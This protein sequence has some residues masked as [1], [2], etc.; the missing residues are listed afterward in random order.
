MGFQVGDIVRCVTY[1]YRSCPRNT[2]REVVEVIDTEFELIRLENSQS[3]T[4]YSNYTSA[5]FELVHRPNKRRPETMAERTKYF[6]I[7][8]NEMG[9]VMWTTDDYD[10]KHQARLAAA[11]LI[12]EGERWLVV[13]KVM[14]LEGKPKS[15]IDVIE[16]QYV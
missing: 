7:K 2:K 15:T 12:K 10:S 6:G 3:P 8:I 14:M 5:N 9:D 4:G 13:Q 1:N 11:Q 16:T